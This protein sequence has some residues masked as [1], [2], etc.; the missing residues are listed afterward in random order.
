MLIDSITAE[1]DL[2]YTEHSSLNYVSDDNTFVE[3]PFILI[4]LVHPFAPLFCNYKDQ[5]PYG[6]RCNITANVNYQFI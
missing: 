3:V 6:D 4:I 5:I 2:F 1:S